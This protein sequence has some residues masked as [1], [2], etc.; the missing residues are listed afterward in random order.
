[1]QREGRPGD[2]TIQRALTVNNVE[3]EVETPLT[4]AMPPPDVTRILRTLSC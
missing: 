2:V 1:M 3:V 4:L